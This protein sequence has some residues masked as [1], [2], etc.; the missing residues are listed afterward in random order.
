MRTDWCNGSLPA[1][2]HDSFETIITT[3]TDRTGS[4]TYTC[5]NGRWVFDSGFCNAGCGTCSETCSSTS[6]NHTCGTVYVTSGTCSNSGKSCPEICLGTKCSNGGTCPQSDGSYLCSCVAETVRWQDQATLDWCNGSLPAAESS[7]TLVTIADTDTNKTG[8]AEYRCWNGTWTLVT[9]SCG[10]D[11]SVGNRSWPLPANPILTCTVANDPGFNHNTYKDIEDDADHV[12]GTARIA[13]YDGAITYSDMQC[14]CAT[15]PRPL[16]FAV[17]AGNGQVTATFSSINTAD[18]DYQARIDTSATCASTGTAHG[19]TAWANQGG[20]SATYTGLTNGTTYHVCLRRSYERCR[21]WSVPNTASVPPVS[22]TTP[23]NCVWGGWG[24]W[25]P[26]VSTKTCNTSFTQTRTRSKTTVENS[27]GSCTGGATETQSAIGTKCNS[28]T[29][30][31]GGCQSCTPV[32][33]VWGDWGEWTPAVS[34]KT[35]GE[36]F[37]QTRTRSKT[38]VE[39][40]GGTCSGNAT[41]TQSAEGTQCSQGSG[42]HYGSCVTCEG[43][44]GETVWGTYEPY[45]GTTYTIYNMGSCSGSGWELDFGSGSGSYYCASSSESCWWSEPDDA[46]Y[47]NCPPSVFSGCSWTSSYTTGYSVAWR[48]SCGGS[49]SW[50]SGTAYSHACSDSGNGCASQAAIQSC[51]TYGPP[52]G[53]SG[54]WTCTTN[55]YDQNNINYST[56]SGSSYPNATSGCCRS[57]SECD[58]D[59]VQNYSGCQRGRRWSCGGKGCWTDSGDSDNASCHGCSASVPCGAGATCETGSNGR[60]RCVT[61]GE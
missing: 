4:A 14:S 54:T 57:G 30:T 60:R 3:D 56:C 49:Y 45:Y 5:T 34:T 19:I 35:C 16:S 24:A 15:A 28:G 52:K 1:A 48:C 26:A 31:S 44:G 13:C 55:D 12:T 22:C 33:C 7:S 11:C 41:Q 40:C 10:D 53:P 29:C 9:R 43:D 36:S 42:C 6:G 32:N 37:T 61:V 39:S 25:T 21:T 27:C 8:S 18:Y 38:T 51:E 58:G 23:V 47:R 20:Q 46:G 50:N 59:Y 17:T 2:S